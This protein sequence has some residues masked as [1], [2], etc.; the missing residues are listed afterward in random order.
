[1]KILSQITVK[2]P[3]LMEVGE[4]WKLRYVGNKPSLQQLKKWIEEGE[5]IGEITGGMYFV[6]VQAAVMGSNDPLLAKM[7]KID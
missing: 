6:D 4:Y 3:R 2:L 1:M 7:L 5:I